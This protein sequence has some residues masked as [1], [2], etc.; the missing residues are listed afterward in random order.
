M[1]NGSFEGLY[2]FL[3]VA[4]I[5]GIDDSCLRKQVARGK[6]VIGE[7]VKK[8]GRTWI[9]TEQAMIKSF[10][11]L[12]FEE[13][14]KKQQ[15][16]EQVKEEKL[17]GVYLNSGS[18]AQK[19]SKVSGQKRKR[20]SKKVHSMNEKEEKIRDSWVNGD[21]KGVELKNFSFNTKDSE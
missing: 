4:E 14:K 8:M 5:Y 18:N 16:K 19:I 9:I 17:N 12:K 10:G 1:A 20:Y 21:I 7:D 2:T 11:A 15:K 13:Y 6:F 3:E